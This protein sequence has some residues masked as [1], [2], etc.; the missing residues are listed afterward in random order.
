MA[1]AIPLQGRHP[2]EENDK[3]AADKKRAIGE[4][5]DIEATFGTSKRIYQANNIRAKF[6]ETA[7]TWI[8]VCF[9]A[10]NVMKFLRGLLR[11]IFVELGIKTLIKKFFIIIDHLVAI[12]GDLQVSV[13]RIN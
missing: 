10:K 2:K 9:F 6:D 11:L 8:G 4:R 3:H 12:W 13:V 7:D 5:N 1:I